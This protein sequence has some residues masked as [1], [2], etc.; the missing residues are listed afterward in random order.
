MTLN[1]PPTPPGFQGFR[2]DVPL[3]VSVRTLPHWRQAGATYFVTFRLADSIPQSETKMIGRLQ[4]RLRAGEELTSE[5]RRLLQ[6]KIFVATERCLDRGR[7][8]CDLADKFHANA[9]LDSLR[10]RDADRWEVGAATVMPNHVHAIVRPLSESLDDCL[11]A[12]KQFTARLI[13]S[14]SGRRGQLWQHETYNR[15]VRD[16]EHLWRCLQYI[17]KNGSVAGVDAVRWVSE[18]WIDCGWRFVDVEDEE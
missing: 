7:G 4:D 11:A 14:A 3:D 16:D 17:G 5:S 2:D 9:V 18:K 6:R 15:I 1:L 12:T 8:R 13:N 10:F